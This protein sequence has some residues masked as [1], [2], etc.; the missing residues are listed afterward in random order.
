MKNEIFCLTCRSVKPYKL[1][2]EVLVKE[3]RGKE[4]EFEITTAICS[5]CGKEVNPHGLI[6]QN[7]KEIDEQYRKFENLITIP[8]IQSLLE[9]YDLGKAPLG[10][11]L[12]FGE[13]TLTRYLAG[14]LPSKKNSKIMQQALQ[15]PDYFEQCLFDNKARLSEIAY[16][17]AQKHLEKLKKI[18]ALSE[19][20]R[21]VISYLF[22]QL[23]EITPLALQKMLYFA[24]AF[25]LARYN[26]ALFREDCQAWKH[27]PVYR[28]VYDIF[29]EFSYNPIESPSFV[30]ISHAK[31]KLT[32][33]QK[34]LIDVLVETFGMYSPKILE[35]ITHVE[36]P[37]IQAR[38]GYSIDAPSN[39]IIPK[40]SIQ[41]YYTKVAKEYDLTDYERIQAYIAQC[42]ANKKG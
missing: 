19:E 29:K 7:M 8:E 13:V 24:Q 1:S 27:G 38:H 18:S 41:N 16:D 40:E 14:Q 21:G 42:L 23:E 37:W 6:D 5:C 11:A 2:K 17:K 25:H 34:A 26:T 3:I 15:D 20:I 22:D 39:E 28:E 4:Y 30:V 9:L 33:K 31:D 36:D 35:K 32:L 10:K 12:G